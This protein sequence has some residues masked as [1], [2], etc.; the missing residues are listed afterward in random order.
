MTE[1]KKKDVLLVSEAI[2]ATNG[3]HPD[4]APV[5]TPA[6]TQKKPGVIDRIKAAKTPEEVTKLVAEAES[7]ENISNKTLSRARRLGMKRQAQLKLK[8]Q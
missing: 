7:Y 4:S 5:S 1:P 3:L 8:G 2:L 6:T